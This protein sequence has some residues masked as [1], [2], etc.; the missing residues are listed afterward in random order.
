ML[1]IDKIID[2]P[3]SAAPYDLRVMPILTACPGLYRSVSLT[4]NFQVCRGNLCNAGFLEERKNS[5]VI[6][7]VVVVV[8]VLVVLVVVGLILLWLYKKRQRVSLVICRRT[9][10]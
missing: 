5:F 4:L 2:Y 9:D 6:I 10:N 3:I 7:I 8:A 1:Y